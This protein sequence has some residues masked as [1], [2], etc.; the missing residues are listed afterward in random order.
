MPTLKRSI[1]VI[2][3]IRH[4][5]KLQLCKAILFTS[6]R[7]SADIKVMQQLARGTQFRSKHF[8]KYNSNQPAFIQTASGRKNNTLVSLH[9]LDNEVSQ[10]F[11]N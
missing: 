2:G 6:A 10:F 3:I 1:N 5:K 4:K 9:A 8:N 11:P 7:G